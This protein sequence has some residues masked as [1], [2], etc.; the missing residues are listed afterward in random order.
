MRISSILAAGCLA[1]ALPAAAQVVRDGKWWVR[2]VTGTETLPAGA[3]LQIASRGDVIVSGAAVGHVSWVLTARTEAAGEAE[4]RRRLDP[5]AVRLSGSGSGRGAVL[6]VQ[7]GGGEAILRVTVPGALRALIVSTGEGRAEAAGLDGDV[8]LASGA[9]ELVA[10]RISGS[11]TAR[12]GGGDIILGGIDGSVRCSTAGGDIRA[13]RIGGEAVLDT[14]GGDVSVEE[15]GRVARASTLGGAVRIRRAGASVIANTGGGLI[16]IG[17]AAGMVELRNAAGPVHV[18][19]ARGVRCETGSGAIRLS[20]V[21]G[22]LRASTAMGSI[23][24]RLLAGEAGPG[25]SF[26]TTGNGDITVFIP[27]NLGVKIR[28]E[29][30]LS[31]GM[32]R[33]VSDFPGVFPRVQGAH[34]VA[35][36]DI[37]GGGPLLRISGTGGTIFIKRH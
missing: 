26:L 22:S 7:H 33:I 18:G 11:L 28:A 4:A 9:G 6:F 1:A 8:M 19:A 35:E 16:E 27:S 29:N 24:A 23:V 21:S 30:G 14:G 34:V 36:A 20:N 25:D 12:S 15:V 37:N 13:R 31:G 3:R 5:A 32:R 2:T 17:E 10:D